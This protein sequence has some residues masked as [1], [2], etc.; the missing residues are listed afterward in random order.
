MHRKIRKYLLSTKK[1]TRLHESRLIRVC[2]GYYPKTSHVADYYSVTLTESCHAFPLFFK[3][4]TYIF[5]P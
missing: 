5:Y 1:P 2:H 4:F 3:I